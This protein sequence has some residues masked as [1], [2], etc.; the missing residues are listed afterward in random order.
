MNNIDRRIENFTNGLMKTLTDH[1][2]NVRD[3][4]YKMV[5]LVIKES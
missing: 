3:Q 5:D 4:I 1:F 2:K